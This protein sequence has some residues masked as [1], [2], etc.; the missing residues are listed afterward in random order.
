MTSLEE[1]LKMCALTEFC[2]NLVVNTL[3]LQQTGVF[4]AIGIFNA[5]VK[6]SGSNGS[7]KLLILLFK[8]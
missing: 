7:Q 8:K 4:P 5:A 3:T 1:V 2:P 6:C